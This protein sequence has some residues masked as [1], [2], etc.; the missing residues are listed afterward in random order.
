M[1]LCAPFPVAT[2]IDIGVA[3]PSAQGHAI[4]NTATALT[5]AKAM[6]GCGPKIAQTMNVIIAITTT[7]GTNRPATVS[8]SFWMGARERW[9]SATMRTICDSIVSS[10]TRVAAM[11]SDPVPL[12]V[13]PV[14]GS[15]AAFSTGIG[16][17][18]IMDSS[19]F[20]RPSTTSPS[21]GTFSPGRTRS[22]SPLWTSSTETSSSWP[23]AMI[24][25]AV[26][27]VS[28]RSAR[29]APDVALR[30]RSSRTCPSNTSV[31]IT[32]AAS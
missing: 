23:S 20:E 3:R 8:A 21:T 16:S 26:G 12:T 27:G 4:I 25:F 30:A 6:A 10:P 29:M 24:R 7:A 1:P 22:R 32:A 17:P 13:P 19:T 31:V 9:A 11:T 28:S 5:I 18:V 15:P 14:I 2:I